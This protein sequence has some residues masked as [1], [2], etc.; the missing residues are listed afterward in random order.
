MTNYNTKFMA[1]FAA[2]AM[3]SSLATA[4]SIAPQSVNSG[5]TKMTQSNGSLSF[6]VGELVV[7][8]QTDANGNTLGNGFTSGAAVSTSVLSVTEANKDLL[9]VKVYPNPTTEL[10]FVD[11]LATK[12][13]WVTI[14]IVDL[15][16]KQLSTQKY[17]GMSNRIGINTASYKAGTYFL[18][19]KDDANTTLATY[20]LIKQ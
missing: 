19:L 12:L 16:G 7:L 15:Q 6:T 10:V 18:V 8:A 13:S 1:L 9:H 11:I 5:G 3:L 2:S 17:A 14:D 20:K 4:Q